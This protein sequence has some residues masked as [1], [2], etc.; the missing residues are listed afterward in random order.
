MSFRKK[1]WNQIYHRDIKPANIFLKKDRKKG[2]IVAKLADFGCSISGQWAKLNKPLAKASEASAW[3]PGYEPP[4]HPEFS[5]LTDVW[6]LALTIASVCTG[7]ICPWSKSEPTGV[8]WDKQQP[9]GRRYTRELNDILSW[10]LNENK[11][12]RPDA[13]AILKRLNET[14]SRIES[15]LP[16]IDQPTNAYWQSAQS[17]HQSAPAVSSPGPRAGGAPVAIPSGRPG[18]PVHAFSDPGAE[19]GGVW[20]NQ[21]QAFGQDQRTP[22]SP[23]SIDQIIRD[24]GGYPQSGL[25]G[26]FSPAY[27]SRG[28]PPGYGRNSYFGSSS[29][30]RNPRRR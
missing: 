26:G 25:P 23:S 2:E 10:C 28:M 24:G 14:Y 30:S 12:K 29:G 19:Q 16:L 13:L 4:E 15:R 5:V 17:A 27:G 7:T 20:Q 22:M 3:T 21:F 8:K 9:G 6:Q 1:Y 11:H 18:P